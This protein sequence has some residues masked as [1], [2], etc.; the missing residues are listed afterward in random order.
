[1]SEILNKTL[2]DGKITVQQLLI[3]I[4]VAIIAILVIKFIKGIIST[5]VV[6]G[7]VI[8]ALMYQGVISPVQV[9]DVSKKLAAQ[10]ITA[11][12]KYADES[13]DVKI[14]DDDIQVKV[15]NTWV[16]VNEIDS[17]VSNIGSASMSVS[18]NGQTYTLDDDKAVEM[19]KD[20]TSGD[21]NAIQKL[22]NMYGN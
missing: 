20:L 9:K 15:G 22:F 16:S 7:V 5:L 19:L 1:M 12:Q 2:L 6:I 11:Y 4:L 14:V 8:V 10:G 17:V 21:E 18:V 3:V 13:D